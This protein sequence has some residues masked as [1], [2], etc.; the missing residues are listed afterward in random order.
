MAHPLTPSEQEKVDRV[1]DWQK[2]VLVHNS[3]GK[4]LNPQALDELKALPIALQLWALRDLRLLA[5]LEILEPLLKNDKLL[6]EHAI[7]AYN[8][9]LRKTIPFL[10]GTDLFYMKCFKVYPP[11]LL[12]AAKACDAAFAK[13]DAPEAKAHALEAKVIDMLA[14][15]AAAAAIATS[16]MNMNFAYHR[17]A[18]GFSV[19]AGDAEIK[20][21]LTKKFAPEARDKFAELLHEGV[22]LALYNTVTCAKVQ[23]CSSSAFQH[24]ITMPSGNMNQWMV[25]FLREFSA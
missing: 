25:K 21:D 22:D 13:A 11:A 20:I 15:F 10:D 16:P 7:E 12:A 6:F 1:L 8:A 18:A 14:E 23:S 19:D 5:P 4:I 24:L 17:T 2:L 3:A 9:R